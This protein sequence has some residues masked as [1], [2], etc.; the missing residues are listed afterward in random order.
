VESL[1]N[2]FGVQENIPVKIDLFL[3][4]KE[5]VHN[6]FRRPIVVKVFTY[7]PH[8]IFEKYQMLATQ[9]MKCH[10]IFSEPKH[11]HYLDEMQV[12][13]YG[14]DKLG[15]LRQLERE[16]V[17]K[18]FSLFNTVIKFSNNNSLDAARQIREDLGEEGQEAK[19][20][21]VSFA[22]RR[23][24]GGVGLAPYGGSQEEYLVRRSNLAW[25][26]DPRFQTEK[27]H[28]EMRKTRQAEGYSDDEFKHHIPYFG[29]VIS[30]NVTFIDG[31]QPDQFDVISSAAPDLRKGSD[32]S[33]YLLENFGDLAAFAQHNI[34]E[35]KI[36]AI[37][38]SAVSANIENLVLGA[39]GTGC[40]NND[41]K[42]VAKIFSN[43][44]ESDTYKGRFNS[45]TFAITEKSKLDIFR[46]TF[47]HPLNP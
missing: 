22:N 15:T 38:A 20:G 6:F 21:I 17:R 41:A 24:P 33:N 14:G 19:I 12:K 36:R 9:I 13:V 37:F 11:H 31:V 29:A 23:Q 7:L 34:L 5:I 40:F 26:L 44:L 8:F 27:L 30:E 16:V 28:E 43:V 18:E 47:L 25:G 10:Q 35:N 2:N 39:F 1:D 32:E 42:E 3:K 4:I 45:I 46:E